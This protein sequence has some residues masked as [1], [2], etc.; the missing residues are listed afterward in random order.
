MEQ[1][2]I[3]M[4][5]NC[6]YF[7]EDEECNDENEGDKEK[8]DFVKENYFLNRDNTMWTEVSRHEFAG[9]NAVSFNSKDGIVEDDF[10]IGIFF[11][12]YEGRC[13]ESS[14]IFTGKIENSIIQ[15]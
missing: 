13:L 3:L 1:P 4:Q 9:I 15:S 12:S 8:C 5:S 11:G 10:N 7:F 14:K 2:E 6:T